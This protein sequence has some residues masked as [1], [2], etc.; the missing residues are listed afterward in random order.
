M[1]KP[2]RTETNTNGPDAPPKVR[3]WDR[4]VRV[5]HWG[6]VVA[7]AIA[8]LTRHS[9]ETIHYMA[10]YAA[11]ALVAL[12]LVWGV[13]GTHYARFRQFTRSPRTVLGYLGDIATGREARYVG[14]NP[15]GGAMIIALILLVGGT[16]VT[17]WLSTTDAFWGVEWMSK[18]HERIAD[19]LLI[20]VMIHVAGVILASLRHRE[21]LVLAMVTGLKREPKPGDVAD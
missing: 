21:N 13:A 1:P 20:L 18:L 10:G 9:S 12:R 4:F 5:F 7:F 19:G 15:A 11:A 6:L 8:W 14:H 17:G 2:A 3:V 16:A